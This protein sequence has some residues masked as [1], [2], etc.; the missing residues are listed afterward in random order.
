MQRKPDITLS[1]K[2]LDWR[3]LVD[4]ND[5]LKKTINYFEEIL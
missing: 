4:L 1:E 5:G 3:P 2:K